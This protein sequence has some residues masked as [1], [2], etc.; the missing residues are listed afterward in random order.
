MSDQPYRYQLKVSP[1]ATDIDLQN[2][3]NNIAY[4][5]Y[6]QDIAVAHWQ[7]VASVSMQQLCTWVV[8]KHEIEYFKPAYLHDL[9][10]I[11]TWVGDSRAATWERWTEI[12]REEDQTLLV[13]ARTVW[14][15]IDPLTKRPRRVDAQLVQE[16]MIQTP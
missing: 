13:K 2:H 5:R 15:L 6:I 7:A 11:V 4:V 14:V 3:V 10:Q 16:F 12:Y 8:R 9:L 1:L